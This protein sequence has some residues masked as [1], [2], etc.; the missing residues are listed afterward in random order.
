MSRVAAAGH[1]SLS[2]SWFASSLNPLAGPIHA[3]RP[4]CRASRCTDP[5]GD[6]RSPIRRTHGTWRVVPP[7]VDNWVHL[8]ERRYETQTARIP[9]PRVPCYPC[10]SM[11][12]VRAVTTPHGGGGPSG[13]LRP[14]RA[15]TLHAAS[16][17]PL[18]HLLGA[19]CV[20]AD[21]VGSTVLAASLAG[22]GMRTGGPLRSRGRERYARTSGRDIFK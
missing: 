22:C 11:G 4:R 19:V 17:R 3:S 20:R 15:A 16:G 10:T 21:P 14:G 7:T 5:R 9:L 2:R 6:L 18:Q 1:G 12:C 8:D 13:L